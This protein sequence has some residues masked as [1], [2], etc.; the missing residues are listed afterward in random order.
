MKDY[1]SYSQI[2]CYLRCP[3]EFK[4]RY[5]DQIE[6]PFAPS[7][8]VFGEAV[9]RALAFFYRQAMEGRSFSLP[10]LLDV[11]EEGWR[12]AG[13]RKVRYREGEDFETLLERGKEMMRVFAA[14]ALPG[15]VIAVE[16]D[17]EVELR[18]P[19]TGQVFHL[20]V[21]GTFDLVEELD[22]R[23]VI[24]DHKTSSRRYTPEDVGDNLQLSI[25]AAAAKELG[26]VPEDGEVLLRMDVLL[27]T[28][29]PDLISYYTRRGD[30]DQHRLFEI[31]SEVWKGIEEEVFY[32]RQDF[33]CRRCPFLEECRGW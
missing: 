32:P 7:S 24:V 23:T 10:E 2:S 9:H 8:V 1:I 26:L 22:G 29:S 25:Y 17:F 5:V 16:E 3:L 21:M 11:F 6:P 14:K 20:P 33:H 13:E 28:K 15:R 18:D 12:E 4:F 30:Q 27:K 19:F 31:V